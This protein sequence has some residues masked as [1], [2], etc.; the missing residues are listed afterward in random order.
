MTIMAQSTR[1]RLAADAYGDLFSLR[2][3]L[4][5]RLGQPIS[6]NETIRE[7]RLMMMAIPEPVMAQVVQVRKRARA[8]SSPL[9][10]PGRKG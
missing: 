4:S 9:L 1:I 2:G 8:P 5:K 10:I 3:E 7:I 6:T